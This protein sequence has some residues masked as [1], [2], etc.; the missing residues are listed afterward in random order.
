[1]APVVWLLGKVQSGKSSIVCALTRESSAEIGTGFSACTKTARVYDFPSET[2]L[3]RFLDT[4]GLGEVAYD[5]SEDLKVA[6]QTAHCIVAVMRA[7]DPH[8]EAVIA[9]LESVRRR[10]PDWPI[11]V[12]QT[13]LHEAYPPGRGHP[14]PYP[15]VVDHEHDMQAVSSAEVAVDLL[16]ALNHQRACVRSL[17]GTGKIAFV[18][19]DFTQEE[20]N[21]HPRLYGLSALES[22][23][24][25]VAP[26]ALNA[27]LADARSETEGGDQSNRHALI[28]GHAAAASA[29]DLVPLAAVA[30]VPAVQANLLR[31]LARAHGVDWSRRFTLEF[32][33]ALG[34]GFAARYA[35]AFGIRQLTKLI[36]VLGQTAAAA[37]AAA[38]SFATT[39]ALGKA[40]DFFLTKRRVGRVDAVAVRRAWADALQEAFALARARGLETQ[41]RIRE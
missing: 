7:M 12:A 11:V 32:A 9:V 33:G 37:A 18:P 6:E 4:R 39:Y 29:L 21:F 25:Y 34:V 20:D 31:R 27:A 14:V 23:L 19:L 22:A 40:A 41:S 5:P 28:V 2:P 36:P 17:P 30:A 35:A 8:Q 26:A 16:R 10:T 15:F 38:T 13:H 1:M 24:A 3:I